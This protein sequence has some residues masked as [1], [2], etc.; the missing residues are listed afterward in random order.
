MT[1]AIW[2]KEYREH[3]TVW[4]AMAAVGAIGLYGLAFV[5]SQDMQARRDMREMLCGVAILLSWAY[6]MVAG[7]MLL[8]GER[9]AAT[10]IYLDGLPAYRLQVWARKFLFGLGVTVAQALVL[11]GLGLGLKLVEPTPFAV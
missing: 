11:A 10:L 8:A 4:A 3:R 2:W 5:F 9:E 7:A 1:G 6:G